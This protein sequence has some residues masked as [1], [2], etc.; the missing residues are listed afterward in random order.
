MSSSQST[1]AMCRVLGRPWAHSASKKAP[2]N[3]LGGP[4]KSYTIT[5]VSATCVCVSIRACIKSLVL[6]YS[7]GLQV[8][9][10]WDTKHTLM[11]SNSLYR[12]SVGGA[13][14]VNLSFS[15]W[16][17]YSGCVMMLMVTSK[18][19]E[20]IGHIRS[21]RYHNDQVWGMTFRTL[22]SASKASVWWRL[23]ALICRICNKAE[24]AIPHSRKFCPEPCSFCQPFLPPFFADQSL[25][26]HQTRPTATHLVILFSLV[27]QT[28]IY[29]SQ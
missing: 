1:W 10:L 28:P 13:T 17:Q 4:A 16:T 27:T 11:M 22:H 18:Q 20:H 21:Q 12:L 19:C 3:S 29:L 6:V 26:S 25:S 9:V 23:L 14:I 5:A 2:L 7:R 15:L 8:H 24:S